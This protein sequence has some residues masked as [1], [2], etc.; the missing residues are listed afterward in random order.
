MYIFD[1]LN[2]RKISDCRS[3]SDFKTL[4]GCRSFNHSVSFYK[5]RFIASRST[6]YNVLLIF[7]ID[8]LSFRETVDVSSEKIDRKLR[9]KCQ[10]VA[11]IKRDF[12]SSLFVFYSPCSIS[13]RHHRHQLSYLEKLKFHS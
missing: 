8:Y 1:S 2:L 4:T 12:Y 10:R 6:E 3:F 9:H 13:C 5:F 7:K 11:K